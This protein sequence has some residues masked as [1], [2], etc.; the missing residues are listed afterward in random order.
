[1]NLWQKLTTLYMTIYTYR[2]VIE[3]CKFTFQ[4][5]VTSWSEMAHSKPY[6]NSLGESGKLSEGE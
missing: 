5:L 1:M 4:V 2:S 6:T 3:E